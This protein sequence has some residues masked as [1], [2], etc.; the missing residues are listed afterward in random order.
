GSSDDEGFDM[1]GQITF[2]ISR[3]TDPLLGEVDVFVRKS[4]V[5]FR[6]CVDFPSIEM[7]CRAVD[8]GIGERILQYGDRIVRSVGIVIVDDD[9]GLDTRILKCRPQMEA[10][11]SRLLLR[12]HEKRGIVAWMQGLILDRQG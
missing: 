2:E 9:L 7:K 4:L 8:E 5:N 11:E 10:D 6:Q 12:K 1:P 3:S